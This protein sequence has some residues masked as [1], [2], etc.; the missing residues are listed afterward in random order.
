MTTVNSVRGTFWTS[1]EHFGPKF[2]L[3]CRICSFVANHALLTVFLSVFYS[4]F[5][6]LS[7]LFCVVPDPEPSRG[8]KVEMTSQRGLTG[9]KANVKC[10]YCGREGRRDKIMVICRDFL[11]CR[12]YAFLGTFWTKIHPILSDLFICRES[13]TFNSIFSVFWT[14]VLM[15]NVINLKMQYKS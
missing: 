1:G 9:S 3:F 5:N 6:F 13:R 10:D 4:I 11:K 2:T 14:L 12:I 15:L 7:L 8:Q